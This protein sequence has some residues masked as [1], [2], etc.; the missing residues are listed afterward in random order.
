[1]VTSPSSPT[2]ESNTYPNPLPF[3]KCYTTYYPLA[4][5]WAVKLLSLPTDAQSGDEF[6]TCNK[7][8]IK[9]QE[10]LIGVEAQNRSQESNWVE[11]EWCCKIFN[12]ANKTMIKQK[13]QVP[14]WYIW[15][16]VILLWP[17]EEIQMWLAKHG[18]YERVC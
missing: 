15:L 7:I 2:L 17:P 4:K 18:Y 10:P 3:P 8:K 5:E 11:I 6:P 16:C 13:K 1:M 12:G 14:H 9:C